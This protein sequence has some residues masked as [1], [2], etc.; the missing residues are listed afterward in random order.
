MV[1]KLADA[2][3][4]LDSVEAHFDAEVGLKVLLCN[5]VHYAAINTNLL[6]LLA[7]LRKL[8]DIA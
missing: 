3:D 8:D 6:K 1:L 7:V 5:V 4:D 2:F